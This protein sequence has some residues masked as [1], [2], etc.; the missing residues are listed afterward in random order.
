LSRQFLRTLHSGWQKE[1]RRNN[2][3]VPA[4]QVTMKKRKQLL[5]HLNRNS[6]VK[7]IYRT[8]N[9]LYMYIQDTY[10]FKPHQEVFEKIFT[11][12]IGLHK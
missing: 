9:D 2:I 4:Y 11:I 8:T 6:G 3:I 7:T 12:G 10:I 5:F 1:N